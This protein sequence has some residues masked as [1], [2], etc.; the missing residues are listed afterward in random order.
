[1][2]SFVPKQIRTSVGDRGRVLD[3]V[4]RRGLHLY[5][6]KLIPALLQDVD[7]GLL[8]VADKC[9]LKQRNVAGLQGAHGFFGR[10]LRIGGKRQFPALR[11]E[12]GGDLLHH[13]PALSQEFKVSILIFQGRIPGLPIVQ[14]RGASLGYLEIRLRKI[15]FH[16]VL[17]S[18]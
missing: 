11:V 1:M 6:V 10:S 17:G 5:Q 18:N 14:F 8:A 4:V 7:S 13:V 3:T 12:Q 2:R 15:P 16:G 9:C